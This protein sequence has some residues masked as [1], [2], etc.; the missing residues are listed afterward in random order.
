MILRSVGEDGLSRVAFLVMNETLS[1]SS[2]DV[3]DMVLQDDCGSS[4]RGRFR[5]WSV[6]IPSERAVGSGLHIPKSSIHL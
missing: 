6:F 4:C 5:S 2:D 3:F 1:P